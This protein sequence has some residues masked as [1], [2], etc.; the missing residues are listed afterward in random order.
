VKETQIVLGR[1]IAP[2]RTAIALK[3]DMMP[4]NVDIGSPLR[5]RSS[6]I[7]QR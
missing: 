4:P 5:V 6:D 7:S 3:T 1:A 2:A